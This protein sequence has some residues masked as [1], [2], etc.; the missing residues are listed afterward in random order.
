[1]IKPHSYLAVLLF[2]VTAFLLCM[3]PIKAKSALGSSD[4]KHDSVLEKSVSNALIAL[5]NSFCYRS[6]ALENCNVPVTNPPKTPELTVRPIDSPNYSTAYEMKLP[7]TAYPNVSRQRHNQLAN[8]S[9]HKKFEADST[10]AA[11]MEVQYPGIVD[12]VKPGN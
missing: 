10:Y 8:E 4:F 2:V 7:S 6:A 3:V 11:Q 1:M 9:L 12:G 5:E